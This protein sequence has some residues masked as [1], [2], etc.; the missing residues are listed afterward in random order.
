[1]IQFLWIS[2]IE[3]IY[4]TI[5]L[6]KV[7]VRR[8]HDATY[9]KLPPHYSFKLKQEMKKDFRLRI[10]YF[11]IY[12]DKVYFSGAGW[13]SQLVLHLYTNNARA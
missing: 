4:Q 1:M 13:S 6:G 7:F 8:V 3:K 2:P 9:G 11:Q 10:K 5:F 12:N